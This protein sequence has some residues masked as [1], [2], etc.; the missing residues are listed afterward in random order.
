MNKHWDTVMTAC[1]DF[2]SLTSQGTPILT[3]GASA[4]T[5]EDV[6]YR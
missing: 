2:A 4:F 3:N 1:T 6:V 5:G